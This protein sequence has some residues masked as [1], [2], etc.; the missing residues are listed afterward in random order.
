MSEPGAGGAAGWTLVTGQPG[1]GKTTL[2]T[3]VLSALQERRVPCRGF[4]TDEVLGN[5][6]RRIGFDVVA[7]P[8]GARG[9]LSRKQ[10]PGAW[11]KTG[12]Y[13]VDVDSFERVALPT[14]VDDSGQAGT[15]GVG[16][17]VCDEIGR[18]ELHSAPFAAAVDRLLR[19]GVPLFGSIAAP[20]Y[21]HRVPFCDRIQAAPHVS[22]TNITKRN[23]DPVRED[24]QRRLCDQF[25]S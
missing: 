15:D 10:G 20:R 6:G 13:S 1:C 23:R 24:L 25:G 21:G 14:L 11:P 3:R 12:P 8:G 19:A 2:I 18:M 22:V 5:D 17:F 16:L 9:R 4:F 7:V